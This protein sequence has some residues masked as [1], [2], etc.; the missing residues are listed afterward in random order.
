[1]RKFI[2]HGNYDPDLNSAQSATQYDETDLEKDRTIQSYKDE[3]DINVMIKRFGIAAVAK[4][5]PAGY[6]DFQE[7]PADYQS[8]LNAVLE[9]ERRFAEVPA[10][11]RARVD[12]NPAKFAAWLAHDAN[13]EEARKLGLIK[14]APPK[15]GPMKVEVVNPPT[16]PAAGSSGPSA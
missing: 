4:P 12:N 14:P 9:A 5:Q 1:M 2:E 8:A 10:A 13:Q 6:Y 7:A 11:I 3:A 15:S 16:P